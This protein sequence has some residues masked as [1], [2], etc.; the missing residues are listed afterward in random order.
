[1]KENENIKDTDLDLDAL[2][3]VNGGMCRRLGLMDDN[4]SEVGGMSK[5]GLALNLV[6]ALAY[7]KACGKKLK[8]MGT[9][10][11]MGGTTNIF[12]CTNTKCKDYNK[13]KNNLEVKWP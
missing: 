5:S 1:M 2:S 3:E 8:D 12:V 13:E 10:R 11:I 9:R 7:C 6:G 4:L